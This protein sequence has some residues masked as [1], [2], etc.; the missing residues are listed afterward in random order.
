MR[1]VCKEHNTG[2][3][4]V[5]NP[6]HTA[7][8]AGS[9][10]KPLTFNGV[11]LTKDGYKLFAKHLYRGMFDETPGDINPKVNQ[12]VKDKNDHFF[13]RYRTLNAYYIYGGRK[14]PYGVVNFPRELEKLDQMIQNRD[15]KIWDLAAGKDVPQKVDDSNTAQLPKITGNRAI[16]KWMSPENERKAFKLDPRFEINCFAS[17][18][19]FPELA[20]P[21]QIRWDSKG[22]LW[23]SCSTTYPQVKPGEKV[24]D[25][26][27]ILED[28]DGDG[29]ADKSSVFADNLRIPLSFDFGDGGVYV[30]EQPHLTFIK[31]TNGDGKADF[32]R[33][34]LTGFGTEDS[35]HAL[36]D[37]T[38]TPDGDLI[39]R[40]SIFHH[41][42]VETP[43]GTVRVRESG[44]FKF[45][46]DTQRLTAFGS[47][48][49]TNPWGL[50]FD[51]WGWHQGSHPVFAAA[52]HAKNAPYPNIHVPAGKYIKAYS[53]TCG[54][55][56][57]YNPHFPEE[58]QGHFIR[59]RYKPTNEI[60]LHKWAEKDSHFI[61]QKQTPLLRS[62]NLSFIPVDV[63]FGPRGALY[64][65]DWYNPVKGHMQYSLRDTR[66]DKTSGRIWRIT[67]KNHPLLKAPKIHSQPIPQLLE[68][69]K[70]YEYRT[71]YWAKRELRERDPDEVKTYLDTWVSKLDPNA[72]QYDHHR[73]EALWLYRSI[74]KPNLDLLNALLQSK[75][76][77]ARAKATEQIRYTHAQM[78]SPTATLKKM[79]A[80]PSG[81]VRL[82]AIIAASYVDSR[83]AVDVVLTAIK[84]PMDNYLTMAARMSLDALSPHWKKDQKLI[85]NPH[86]DLMH[87]MVMSEPNNF[88]K[89][90]KQRV[91]GKD[92]AFDRKNPTTIKIE[93]EPERLLY[94]NT[95]FKVKA[96]TPV[97]V[98]F[99]NPDV[100]PHNLVFVKPGTETEVGL[101]A[102]EMAKE[103]DG[104]KKGFIPNTKSILW[105][106]PMLN[107]HE[108]HTLRFMAPKQPG[109]YPY[110]CTFP[111]HWLVMKG[112]MIVE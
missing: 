79:S 69:L 48:R 103:P 30:S 81:L 40:E 94:T 31:D 28:I 17:E 51:K 60:E 70:S 96:G 61:E 83:E 55:E 3:I 78:Q 15:Q 99:H 42:Q 85:Q 102:N 57:I 95:E 71:R 72:P 14:K 90:R 41:S 6:T 22:R 2:F 66:R 21:I 45:T 92:R 24:N 4:D 11:H 47:Y 32:R 108:T 76:H 56:F 75:N 52:V 101:A 53:G 80:D 110:I 18:E 89:V 8:Q 9:K 91:T 36:H 39:F 44:F 54:Q 65:C 87:F 107:Q 37:F 38:W 49:S 25:K 10:A 33:I 34:V 77:H 58:L 63:R 27:I 16:N 43:Y 12:A 88:G 111:G 100:T 67:A 64:V 5:F 46:P 86:N 93:T 62:T 13:Q 73:L 98:I 50:T 74:R 1:S 105:H 7:M 26:L 104:L 23:V 20:C 68:H 29:K 19:D 84:H 59:V 109:R 97:K 82:E 35:H 112:V 106:T